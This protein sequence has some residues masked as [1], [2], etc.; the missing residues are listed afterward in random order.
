MT[1]SEIF[2]S[3]F[4]GGNYTLPFM[5]K[6]SHPDLDSI[7]VVN[8]NQSI[9]Y[10]GEIYIASDFSYTQPENNGTGGT[11]N[12]SSQP[13]ENNLFEFV[14]NADHRYRLDVVGALLENNTIQPIKT[15]KHFYGSVTAD[16]TG[17]LNFQ[18]GADDRKDM[19]FTP[20][21]FDT[22]NNRGNA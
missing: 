8:N 10:N 17:R 21:I 22:D 14:E 18:L 11:L 9:E 1:D 6:F 2:N 7:C 16:R 12:I 20:Y 4:G 13:N 3:L 19:T 5:L 15:Y